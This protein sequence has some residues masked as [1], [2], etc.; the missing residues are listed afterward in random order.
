VEPARGLPV[1]ARSLLLLALVP[2]LTA[3]LPDLDPVDPDVTFSHAVE[4][5]EAIGFRPPGSEG[6][7]LAGQYILDTFAD[8]GL[9]D[10]HFQEFTVGPVAG[11][12]VV[13]SLIGTTYPSS[14]LLVGAHYDSIPNGVGSAD[15]A[16][17][18]AS[19]LEIA[20]HYGRHPPAYTIRFVAFDA[21][22]IGLLGSGFYYDQSLVQGELDDTLLMLN[23]DITDTNDFPPEAPLI[24][25]VVPRHPPAREAFRRAKE[26]TLPASALMFPFDPELAAGVFGGGFFGDIH[27]WRDEP[28]LLAW[29]QTYG[30]EYHTIPGSISEIDKI[31]LAVTTKIILEFLRALQEFPPE[32]LQVPGATAFQLE[33]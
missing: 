23:L 9:E 4:L 20:R 30:A 10:P 32:D 31:G 6:G 16:T 5:V 24:T 12:N 19:L 22:E 1:R 26:E 13:A 15:N 33:E 17:G 29:P 3:C 14:I 8:F 28:L 11:R 25:F 18:V 27:H 21:E 2:V 7:L